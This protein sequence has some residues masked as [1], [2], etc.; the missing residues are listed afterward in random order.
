MAE[1]RDLVSAIAEADPARLALPEL[2]LASSFTVRDADDGTALVC[3]GN[4][5]PEDALLFLT[6][7]PNAVSFEHVISMAHD[8]VE[9]GYPGCLGCGGPGLEAPWD[10]LAWRSRQDTT[11]F[12]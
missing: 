4:D 8:L 7:G 11:S 3:W 1:A 5:A 6:S 2:Q 10:E 9:A 12:K